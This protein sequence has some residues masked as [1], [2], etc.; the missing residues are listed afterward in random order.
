MRS[1]AHQASGCS[2]LAILENCGHGVANRQRA[3]LFAIAREESTAADY[4]PACLQLR[5]LDK[6][7]I[8]VTYA[9]GIEHME[10]QPKSAGGRLYV[11]H[12]DF[13]N[14]GIGWVNEKRHD[15]HRRD[16]LVQQ[17]QPL[18]CHLD[19]RLGHARQ[20]AARPVQAGD[21]AE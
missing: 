10:L 15:A 9:A 20:V 13:E 5:Q 17:F 14:T 4:E 12:R 21:E 1:V 3:E 16:N 2:E 6:D 8:E 18:R 19:V 11:T 7:S